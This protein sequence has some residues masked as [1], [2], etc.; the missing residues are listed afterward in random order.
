MLP[1][2]GIRVLDFSTL[3]PGPLAS[4]ILAEA[5]AEVIKVER[6][7]GEEM[8]A[9]APQVAGESAN[10]ALLNRG[11]RSIEIDLRETGAAASLLAL[12][13]T[14]DVVLE[15]F[16][17]GVMARLGLGYDAWREA[18]PR[19]L[20][21][22]ITGYGQDGP[23]AARAGHDLNYQAGSGVL[24]LSA[25]SDGTPG[26][27]PVLLADI[28]GGS[29]PAVINI[30]LALRQRD[31]TGV[32]G[33]LDIAMAEN[34]LPFLFWGLAQG[35]ATGRFP[36]AN[37][38]QFTGASPRY[39]IYRTACGRHLAAAPLENKF[40]QAFCEAI[41]LPAA[42][43]DDALDPAATIEAVSRRL[44]ERNADHWEGVFRAADCC[45]S[46]VRTLDEAVRDLHL[47]ARGVFG[48]EVRVEGHVLQAMPV[49]L[50]RSLRRRESRVGSPALG[51]ARIG[52]LAR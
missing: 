23:D 37:D 26:M 21:C 45:V 10:F 2:E 29:Y 19:I 9:Y 41:G 40:W 17:P 52:D 7:G 16:R 5:G 4:L 51:E 42:H 35:Q 6:P 13:P 3:L 47:A 11:K 8:R 20:Y 33:F 18:N 49:A 12:A 38:A 28:A 25:G 36:R 30:L 44:A 39:R 1:L 48:R 22:A 14:V 31:R 15:Q 27:P 50:V 34:L 46:V 24:S 32:G 43:R